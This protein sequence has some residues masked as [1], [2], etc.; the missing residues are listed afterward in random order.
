MEDYLKITAIVQARINSKRFPKKIFQKIKNKTILEIIYKRLKKSKLLDEIIFAIPNSKN[1][2]VLKNFL[3][4]KKFK[5]HL[6]SNKNI[7]DRYFKCAKK[8]KSD[9]IVRIT[10]DCPLIDPKMLDKMI[11]KLQKYKLDL[12]TN[13]SPATF[14]DGLDLAV[15]NFNSLFFAWKNAN[16]KFDK[17][18][19]IP[20]LLKNNKI[21][22]L[23]ITNRINYSSERWTLDEKEDLVVLK[24][25]FKKFKNFDFSWLDALREI[26]K[27]PEEFN[28]NRFINRNEGSFKSSGQ[29]L[30]RKAKKLIPGGT[31]LLSKNPDIFLPNLWPAYYSKSKGSKIWDL[32]GKKFLDMSLMGV[33]TNILGYNNPKVDNAVK[34]TVQKGNLTTL[35]SPE[36]VLLAEKLISIHPW[37]GMVRFT[38]SGGEANSVAIR[39]ARAASKKYKIAVCGYHG[40]HDWYLAANLRDKS[41]LNSHLIEGLSTR[42]VPKNLLGSIFTFEYNNF[43]EFYKLIKRNPEIG[44]VK[45]EVSRNFNP[46]NNFLEKIRDLTK[47]KGILL[48]F[49]ECTSGFRQC[50]GGLHKIYNIVPDIAIFGK[51]LGNGYAI[52]AIIGKEEYMK[53]GEQTFISSTFWTERIGSTA[54]LKT[55]EEMKRIKSWKII[56]NKGMYIRKKWISLAKKYELKLKLFGLPALSGFEI[57][58]KDFYKYKTLISQEMIKDSIL[59]SNMIYFSTTHTQQDIDKYLLSLEKVF[60][61]ISECESGRKVDNLLDVPVAKNKFQRL[62]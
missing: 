23:N 6:G 31:M 19:V 11:V 1:E 2:L 37:A 59:A 44:I 51:A 28:A 53:Y 16:N 41:R 57:L 35:N 4:K 34:L 24:N 25:I 49:D 42:G 48:I 54:A 12:V 45:M 29:N 10:S 58:S 5:Y 8:N 3:K 20:F 22:K 30:W 47:K 46:K 56:T 32:D 55:L 38:R 36:E 43:E 7:L 17:Q 13:Y 33:G 60:K 50:F 61:L 52:N 40:W 26:K 27:N 14:P 21:K 9:I 18:H 39:I 62:N 15:L